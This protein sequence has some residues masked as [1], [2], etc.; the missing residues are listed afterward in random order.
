[1]PSEY[2]RPDL[3]ALDVRP[4]ILPTMADTAVTFDDGAAYER[5]MG[6]WSRA[7]G[8]IF[9]DWLAPPAGARWLD[10]GCG[11]GVLTGLILDISSPAAVAAIDPSTAQIEY[12]R[13]QPVAERADFRVADAQ[14]LP[15][16]DHSFDAIVSALAINFIPDRPRALLEMRRVG[17][18]GG[19]VAGYVWDFAAARSSSWPLAQGLRR[20]GIEPPL[21]PGTKDSTLDALHSLFV[22]T[23]LEDIAVRSIE[24]T[25]TFPDFD[26]YWRSQ[27]PPFSPHGKAIAGLSAIDRV[28]LMGAVRTSLPADPNGGIAYSARANAIK[29]RVQA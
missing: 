7:V 8:T 29:S 23:G 20:I 9:L 27:T 4:P 26:T 2:V 15:F 25:V 12:A 18:P 11:T 21:V 13:R 28:K 17:Q 1:M 22:Q 6:R 3:V 19:I 16:P 14:A 10:V 5:F 24:V